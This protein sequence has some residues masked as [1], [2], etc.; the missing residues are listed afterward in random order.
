MTE[1]QSVAIW[2]VYGTA[3]ER[4]E[5]YRGSG[6]TACAFS[7]YFSSADAGSAALQVIRDW[8][9]H[10]SQGLNQQIRDVSNMRKFKVGIKVR[11]G[12]V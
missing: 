2:D 7:E 4:S 11:V 3:H 5:C 9:H 6:R 1:R 12:V 8:T 10:R